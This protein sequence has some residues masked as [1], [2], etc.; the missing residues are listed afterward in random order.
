MK[1]LS[2]DEI[3][4]HLISVPTVVL[5]CFSKN[6]LLILI[7]FTL[8]RL[9]YHQTGFVNTTERPALGSPLWHR[10]CVITFC[11]TSSNLF[12]T[13]SKRLGGP[14]A[15]RKSIRSPEYNPALYS[16]IYK[17]SYNNSLRRAWTQYCSG[18][19]MTWLGGIPQSRRVQKRN[20]AGH[21]KG[22][23]HYH[24]ITDAL[25][26]YSLLINYASQIL[27]QYIFL[28]IKLIFM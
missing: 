26:R 2:N 15:T 28:K 14:V 11:P 22:F 19:E 13:F 1:C 3:P 23:F 20:P 4:I 5:V 10:I 9:P 21:G 16:S 12:A 18:T 7:L 24:Q 25:R 6:L 17:V 8:N 27:W